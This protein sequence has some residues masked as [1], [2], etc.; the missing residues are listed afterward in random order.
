[1]Q[2]HTVNTKMSVKSHDKLFMTQEQEKGIESI[3]RLMDLTNYL[4]NLS[5]LD[6]DLFVFDL[7]FL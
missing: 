5:N 2:K 7:F 1:M 4:I 6:L 3:F